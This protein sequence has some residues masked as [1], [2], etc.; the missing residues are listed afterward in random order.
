MTD[1]P[2]TNIYYKIFGGYDTKIQKEYDSL[3]NLNIK[4]LGDN[5]TI[6]IEE[7]AEFEVVNHMN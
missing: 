4:R 1:K 2:E 3:K 5:I 7:P 6:A